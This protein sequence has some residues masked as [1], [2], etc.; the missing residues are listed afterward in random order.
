MTNPVTIARWMSCAA[1]LGTTACGGA[2]T[3][4]TPAPSTS[5]STLSAAANQQISDFVGATGAAATGA[6]QTP[7]GSIPTTQMASYAGTLTGMLEGGGLVADLELDVNFDT[8]EITATADGFTHETSGAMAGALSGTGTVNAGPAS[9]LPQV[10]FDLSGDLTRNGQTAATSL[11]L[12]G[13]FFTVGSDP[14]AAVA[15]TVEGG[16]GN[17]TLTEGLFA[18]E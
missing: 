14:V 10:T 5:F 3:T 7:N 1:L 16:I 8:E 13:G 11:A 4:T 12:D 18:V 2:T 17:G 6:I 9:A 15:G